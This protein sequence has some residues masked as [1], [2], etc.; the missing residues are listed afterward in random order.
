M[1]TN[2]P[3]KSLSADA[4][5][6]KPP[7]VV[8]GR[9]FLRY[10]VRTHLIQ[11]GERLETTLLP[12]LTGVRRG[13]VVAIGEKAVAIAEGR[14]VELADVEPRLLARWLA[15]QVRSLGY[16]LGLRR[17]ET[18]E[19]ALREGGTCR[20]LGASAVAAMGRLLGRS[21]DFY[22]IVGP[23][24]A[25]IDGP[26]PTTLP[27]YDRMIVLSPRDPGATA[28]RLARRFGVAVAVVD[29]NDLGCEV[30]G[31]S[32]GVDVP[33]VAELLRD[34]PMGQGRQRTPVV[35]LRPAGRFCPPP[36]WPV[37]QMP[38]SERGPLVVAVGGL[39]PEW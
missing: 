36:S 18:M 27:P 37:A 16:G 11:P 22:R 30:L 1:R 6:A 38:A 13:D 28:V 7:R 33:T 9:R 35:I 32:R 14:V 34:N 24:V 12:Y 5:R 4:W 17:P 26:G 31:W 20:V 25:A 23:R 29:A 21:G 2:Q 10:A 3:D 15:R 39:A 19:M 8:G